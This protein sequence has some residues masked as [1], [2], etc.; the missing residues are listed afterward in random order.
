MKKRSIV[1]ARVLLEA[2]PPSLGYKFRSYVRRNKQALVVASVIQASLSIGIVVSIV[3]AVRMLNERD[4]ANSAEL[5]ARRR[6][7]EVQK[8]QENTRNALTAATSD[9]NRPRMAN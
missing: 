9:R 8:E 4:R 3:L 7:A 5:L 1:S 2:C 6:L